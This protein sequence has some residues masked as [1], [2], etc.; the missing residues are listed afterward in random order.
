M[1]QVIRIPE[2]GKLALN[3]QGEWRALA[4]GVEP[5]I[6][7]I[8]YSEQDFGLLSNVEI[9]TTDTIRNRPNDVEEVINLIEQGLDPTQQDSYEP[10]AGVNDTSAPMLLTTVDRDNLESIAATHFETSAYDLDTTSQLFFNQKDDSG[11]SINLSAVISGDDIGSAIEDTTT[12]TLTDSGILEISDNNPRDTNFNPD[13]VIPSSG[14]LGALTIDADGNWV[15]NV[16]NADVQYLAQDE[17][18]IETFTVASVDG[19]THDI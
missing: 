11:K 5:E 8:V 12:P 17:T 14:A 4:Q 19:T 6:G 9:I 15:Y 7:D 10:S 3:Q 18:K 13:S 1:K 16:D 2:G